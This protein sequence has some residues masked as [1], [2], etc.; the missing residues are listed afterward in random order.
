MGVFLLALVLVS[1]VSLWCA[2]RAYIFTVD[3]E[4]LSLD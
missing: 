4:H 3:W 1:F 2:Y